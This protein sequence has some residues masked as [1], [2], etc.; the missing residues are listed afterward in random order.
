MT[1]RKPSTKTKPQDTET[2]QTPGQKY[3]TEIQQMVDDWAKKALEMLVEDALA[4]ERP[5][6]LREIEPGTSDALLRRLE[7]IGA[8]A[9]KG[10]VVLPSRPKPAEF[11]FPPPSKE[12]VERAA[13]RRRIEDGYVY[14]VDMRR[15]VNED[16][17]RQWIGPRR[18]P[19]NP[20]W[21]PM[22]SRSKCRRSPRSHRGGCDLKH[23]LSVRDHYPRIVSRT[24]RPVRVSSQ[25]VDANSQADCI[26]GEF[27]LLLLR[28]F[29][30]G[31][32]TKRSC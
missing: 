14:T 7:P 19:A 13:Q 18:S 1:K 25:V 29:P 3:E 22:T 5:E 12:S 30:R 27:P 23:R 2:E 9:V 28:R 31:S 4:L 6:G 17:A 15:F 20:S 11:S 32:G 16:R 24:A 21:I 26:S 10:W 8:G